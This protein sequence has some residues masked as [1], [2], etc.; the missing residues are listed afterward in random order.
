MKRVLIVDDEPVIRKL[1]MICLRG[2]FITEEAEDGEKALSKAVDGD[3]DCVITLRG[4]HHRSWQSHSG[5]MPSSR[6]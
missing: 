6:S 3:Y 4:G 1:I 2:R 5:W